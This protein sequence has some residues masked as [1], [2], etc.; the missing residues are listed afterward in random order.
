MRECETL[1]LTEQDL[2]STFLQPNLV[3]WEE[4]AWKQLHI[5]SLQQHFQKN[6]SVSSMGTDFSEMKSTHLTPSTLYIEKNLLIQA[7]PRVKQKQVDIS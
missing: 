1:H 4:R 6:T 7:Q 2:G 5:T 3:D